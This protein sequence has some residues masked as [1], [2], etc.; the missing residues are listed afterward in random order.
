MVHIEDL[1]WIYTLV[2]DRE[3]ALD[4]IEI[5]LSRPSHISVPFLQLDPRW[6]SLREHPRFQE[7]ARQ[8]E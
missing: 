1:A 7:L 2:G 6:A 5:L 8:F 3:A 4:Q